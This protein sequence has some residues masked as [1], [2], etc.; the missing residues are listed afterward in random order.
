MQSSC[1]SDGAPSHQVSWYTHIQNPRLDQSS[2]HL[3]SRYT[4]KLNNTIKNDLWKFII[5][6]HF[7]S[8]VEGLVGWMQMGAPLLVA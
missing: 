8:K 5:N 7:G 2:N 3:L 1:N 6:E 4:S